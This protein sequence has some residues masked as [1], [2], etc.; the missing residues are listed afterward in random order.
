MKNLIQSLKESSLG[1]LTLMSFHLMED[2][3]SPLLDLGIR[4]WMANVFWKSGLSKIQSWPTTLSLF[5][6]EYKVPFLN[7]KAAAW[8]TTITEL[9]C[10]VLLTIGLATRLA[11]IPMLFMT[12]VIQ[13]TYLNHTDHIYWMFLLGS[14]L[15]RGPGKLSLDSFLF[16]KYGN[17]RK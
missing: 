10:P 6:H 4:L 12:A 8:S 11:T 5:Q 9:S 15:L 16:E 13:F 3:L 2:F 1:R 17:E 14:L 7:Y